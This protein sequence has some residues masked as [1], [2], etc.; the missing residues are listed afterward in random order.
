MP[1]TLEFRV[2][3]ADGT[4]R[5]VYEKGQ[6]MRSP[7]GDPLWLDGAIFD[8]TERTEALHQLRNS[9]TRLELAGLATGSAVYEWDVRTRDTIWTESMTST[10]GYPSE[11]IEPLYD[12]WLSHVHPEDRARVGHAFT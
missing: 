10:F 12:W 3:R 6:A 9:H 1:F 11:A 7:A 4:L 5:W 8:I 2:V